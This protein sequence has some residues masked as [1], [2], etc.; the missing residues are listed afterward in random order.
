MEIYNE[1]VHDLLETSV[2]GPQQHNLKVREHPKDG[3]YVESMLCVYKR[4]CCCGVNG[5][6]TIVNIIMFKTVSRAHL[7]HV[8]TCRSQQTSSV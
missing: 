1:R 6:L 8:R 7:L 2:G 3:P 5:I 4:A